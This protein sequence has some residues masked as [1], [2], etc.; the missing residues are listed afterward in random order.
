MA[1]S[2]MVIDDDSFFREMIRDFLQHN[3]FTVEVASSWL[4]FGNA[5]YGS[6]KVPDVILFDVNLGD[7]MPG[8]KLLAVFKKGRKT[9]ASAQR[10]KLVLLSGLPE[11]ELEDRARSCG[12][13]GYIRKGTL[14]VSSGELFLAKLKRFLRDPAMPL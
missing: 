12:A 1:Y 13:D 7:T 3:G 8:D 11:A 5:F 9:L 6:K 2:V 14:S 10:T 4:D